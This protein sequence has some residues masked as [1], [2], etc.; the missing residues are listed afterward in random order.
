MDREVLRRELLDLVEQG[1]GERPTQLTD[2]QNLREELKLDSID[3]VS[4]VIEVQAK[5]A[6]D[7]P[8]PE[9]NNIVKVGDLLD[10]IQNKVTAREETRL[11]AA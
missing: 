11:K 4:L 5:Y 3:L 10:V 9:L 6:I 8:T 7:I 2:E 1:V